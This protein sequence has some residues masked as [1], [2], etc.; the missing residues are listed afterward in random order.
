MRSIIL[1]EFFYGSWLAIGLLLCLL[2]LSDLV[3]DEKT[4]W[5]LAAKRIRLSLLWP[6]A[7]LTAQGR[8][9]LLKG[10]RSTQLEDKP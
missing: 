4:N 10:F 9:N 2:T 3:F 8:S 1:L 5:R 7:L 6:L